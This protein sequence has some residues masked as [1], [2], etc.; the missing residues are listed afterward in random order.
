MTKKITIK[1]MEVELSD[2]QVENLLEQLK[3]D[4]GDRWKPEEEDKYFYVD[5]NGYVIDDYYRDFPDDL[6]RYNQR[7]VWKTKEEALAYKSYLEAVAKI[8]DSATLQ[9][10]WGDISQAK[11]FVFYYHEDQQLVYSF[12]TDGQS[13]SYAYYETREEVQQAIKTLKKEY[14]LVFEW[15]RNH[16]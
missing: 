8:K 6:W 2:K 3:E 16:G 13:T 14:E 4:K 15:E 11:Y 9:P 12:D 5:C 10:D 1:D 7:N